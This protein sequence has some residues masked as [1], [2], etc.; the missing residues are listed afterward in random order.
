[1]LSKFAVGYLESYVQ[2][3]RVLPHK[4]PQIKREVVQRCAVARLRRGAVPV[5][6]GEPGEPEELCSASAGQRSPGNPDP[7]LAGVKLALFVII[8]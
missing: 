6:M 7:K 8:M 1:M 3:H 5:P 4:D 2:I